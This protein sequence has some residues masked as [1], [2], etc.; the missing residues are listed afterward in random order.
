MIAWFLGLAAAAQAPER[1]PDYFASGS[2]PFWGL[3]I[4]GRQIRFT[5]NDGSESDDGIVAV[6]PRRQPLRGGYRLVTR[7]FTVLVRH[8]ACEDVGERRFRDTVTVT[9]RGRRYLGCGGILLPPTVLEATDWRIEAIGTARV[10]GDGYVMGFYEGR[11]SAQAGCN[12]LTGPF[13]Q[14]GARLTAG[15]IAATRMACPGPRMAHERTVLRLLGG[16][17]QISYPAGDVLI[18]TGS[19]VTI[20]LRRV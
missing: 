8:L 4:R 3:E 6:L 10:D 15:P 18:L 13:R 20:R 9:M 12:R 2:E 16:P 17:M 5:P 11:I 7:R 14:R 19:G 1:A